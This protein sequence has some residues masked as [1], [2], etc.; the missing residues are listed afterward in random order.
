MS[1]KPELE[2]DSTN[3]LS[4]RKLKLTQDQY[5]GLVKTLA[6]LE[7][8]ALDHENKEYDIASFDM[9]H[10]IWPYSGVT[11]NCGSVCCIGG[12]AATV[13]GNRNLYGIAGTRMIGTELMN[14]FYPGGE[15]SGNKRTHRGWA[16]TPKE[17]AMVLRHYLETGKADWDLP[18]RK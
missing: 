12:T 3:F 4:A 2:L 13:M 18:Y 6:L 16:A 10:W 14:V 5:C 7:S 8:G 15:V 11:T 9:N 1:E 17:A